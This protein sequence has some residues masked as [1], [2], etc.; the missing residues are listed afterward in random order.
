MNPGP[1]LQFYF[2]VMLHRYITV[3]AYIA[4]KSSIRRLV[5][6][7]F[8]VFDFRIKSSRLKYSIYHLRECAIKLKW[9]PCRYGTI[10]LKPPKYDPTKICDFTRTQRRTVPL[11]RSRG[12]RFPL[13][14]WAGL[15]P[16]MTTTVDI[17]S[18][19]RDQNSRVH[20]EACIFPAGPRRSR[21][22]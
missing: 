1:D 19:H 12:A 4:R 8:V 17:S 6:Y 21:C 18:F 22:R 13:A 20:T 9:S 16:H 10:S 14:F 3:N 2:N 11:W 7:N 5:E 15:F